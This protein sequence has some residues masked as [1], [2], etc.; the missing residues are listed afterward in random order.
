MSIICIKKLIQRQYSIDILTII[1]SL[2]L[3]SKYQDSS[4]QFINYE[5]LLQYYPIDNIQQIHVSIYIN[6]PYI[7][8]S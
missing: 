7:F 4:S 6:L 1:A 3:S 8:L 2:T 5:I